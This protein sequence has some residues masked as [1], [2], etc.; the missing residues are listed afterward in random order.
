MLKKGEIKKVKEFFSRLGLEK[1]SPGFTKTVM[2]RIQLEPGIE[3]NKILPQLPYFLIALFFTAGI[4]VIPFY[5]YILN[6]IND[7]ILRISDIDYTFLKDFL[8]SITNTIRDY[9]VSSTV[10]VIFA[11]STV[12]F[13]TMILINYQGYKYET[14]RIQVL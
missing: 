11:A 5:D 4:F 6:F 13:I 10:L 9:S 7:L 1:T 3:K 14:A 2:S 8:I 12:L